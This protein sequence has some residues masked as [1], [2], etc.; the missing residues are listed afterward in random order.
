MA[1]ADKKG[2]NLASPFKLQAEELLDV[3]QQVNSITERNELVTLHAATAGLRVYVKADKCSYVYNGS[4]WDKIATSVYN[5]PTGDGNLHVP[6]TGTSHNNQVLTAGSTAGSIAWKAITASMITDL[7]KYSLSSFGITAS[8]DELNYMKG[9]TSA[10]QTQLDEKATKDHTHGEANL[11][12][13]GKNISDGFGPVDAAMIP[14]LGANRFACIL[15][16]LSYEYTTNGGSTW[17]KASSTT[18]L[19]KALSGYQKGHVDIGDGTSTVTPAHLVRFT[20]KTDDAFLY[21]ALNKFVFYV[22]TEGADGCWCTIEGATNANPSKFET[23]ANKVPIS[24]WPGWNVINTDS[25]TTYSN[26]SAQYQYLRFTFGITSVNSNSS[27]TSRLTIYKV[28]AFGGPAWITPSDMADTGHMYGWDSECNVGFPNNVNARSFSINNRPLSS[29]FS[30]SDHEHP[31]ADKWNSGFMPTIPDNSNVYL[32]GAGKWTTPPDTTYTLGSF[33]IKASYT[34]LNYM[35]GVTSPVQTQLN[36][37]AAT[38]HTH[39]LATTGAAGFMPKLGGGTSTFLRADGTWATPPNN[40]TTYSKFTGASTS[41]AG[42]IGL[43]PAPAAGASNR[44]LRSDG[45]WSV[46]PDTNTW[47]AMKGATGSAAGTAGYVPAPAAGTANRYLRSDGTWSVPPDTNTTYTLNTFGITASAAE[48]NYMKGVTSAVQTQL[49]GKASSDHTH[50][51][52]GSSSAGGAATSAVSVVDY[53]NTAS[54]ISIGFSGDGLSNSTFKYFAGYDGNGHIKDGSIDV[55][56]SVLGLSSYLPTSGGT[57]TGPLKFTA[58]NAFESDP[59][60]ILGIESFDNGG[61]L[62]YKQLSDLKVG[63]AS[64]ADTATTATSAN[65]A[66]SA[67]KLTSNAGSATQPVY[68]TGG[69]PKACTYTLGKSVPSNAV[70]TDTWTA[71]KGATTSAAGTAG[72][73]PAPTAGAANRYLR[74]DGTWSVPPDTNTTYTL[75]TFGITAS[76]TELNYVKGVTSSI[77]TQLNGKASSSHSHSAATTSAAGFMPKLS[78]SSSQVLR[79]DGT[80]GSV[81]GADTKVTNTLGTTTKAYITGT[82]SSA[83]NTGTQVFDTGV[84]LTDTPGELHAD[85]A[86]E[87]GGASLQ[88]DSANK[89]I[90]IVFS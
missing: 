14:Q 32:N 6:A 33:G 77:Q 29:Y 7:P 23:F 12:W 51:Y 49:N 65:S 84:Y 38:G 89:R 17:T 34:E 39:P 44:Y 24:G 88:W 2:I 40:D 5:H 61:E 1:F 76:A 41:A 9:V 26:D 37:K 71:F 58:M 54:T 62:K 79:G 45:T 53:K 85:S 73:A 21:A 90:A 3:R 4:G 78:G 18:E 47:T 46:P 68:F 8:A 64:T 74:S 52:A 81:S 22:S 11:T 63:S 36:G 43:V 28:M 55:V 60:Y 31:V 27:Y 20:I 10:V 25:I 13:G 70:F 83:T 42:A 48:L 75:S 66:T 19:E 30:S 67:T 15:E 80:W 86:V 56:K 87:I 16:G 69:A 57:I 35:K 82:T 59:S 50:K 72:Y